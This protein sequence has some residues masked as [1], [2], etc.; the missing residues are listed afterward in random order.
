[1]RRT[2]L[3]TCFDVRVV[4][5]L[6]GWSLVRWFV[7]SLVR[8]FVGSLVRW[9]VGWEKDPVGCNYHY[10]PELHCVQQMFTL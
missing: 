10:V 4:G 3:F 7:G 9:F 6:V 2:C 8:W 1:M 5:S